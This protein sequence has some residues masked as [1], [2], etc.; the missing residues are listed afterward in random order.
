MP[1]NVPDNYDQWEA[2]EARKQRWL[3]SLPKCDHCNNPIQDEEL[4]DF[5]GFL[6]CHECLKNHYTKRTDDYTA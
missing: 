4:V 2:N 1:M 3:D 6:I 5:D